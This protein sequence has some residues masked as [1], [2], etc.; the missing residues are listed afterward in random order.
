MRNAPPS[1]Q[2]SGRGGSALAFACQLI[3]LECKVF[4]VRISFNQKP[5]RKMMMRVWGA[6]C[7]ASP[8]TQASSRLLDGDAETILVVVQNL[9]ELVVADAQNHV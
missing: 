8:S 4:M 7:I 6:D 1:S 3:G 5:F 2:P 9:L